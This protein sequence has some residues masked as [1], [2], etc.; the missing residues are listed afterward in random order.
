MV[1]PRLLQRKKLIGH[2]NNFLVLGFQEAGGE[3]F[4]WG[5]FLFL[6]HTLHTSTS[7]CHDLA[8]D[9]C[10]HSKLYIILAYYIYISISILVNLYK[11][12]YTICQ[13]VIYDLL[14]IPLSIRIN[15]QFNSLLPIGIQNQITP[16]Y[17]DITWHHQLPSKMLC[18]VYWFLKHCIC[19][20]YFLHITTEL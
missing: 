12:I 16:F 9:P 8:L 10:K 1:W 20:L 11:I 18:L 17:N 6:L 7:S 15:M 13:R 2:K 3:K 5:A 4:Y 14:Y 19:Q